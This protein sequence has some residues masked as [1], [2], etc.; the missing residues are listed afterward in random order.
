[1]AEPS[2]T[3]GRAAELAAMVQGIRDR[4][5]ARYPGGSAAGIALPDLT[6]VLHARDAAEGKV[7]AIGTVNPRS[8]GLLNSAVQG[9][10]R[11]VARAL[12]WHVREQIEYNRAVVVALVAI[13][14]S[15]NEGNR[16]IAGLAHSQAAHAEAGRAL[17]LNLT[18]DLTRSL[19]E[20]LAALRS[21]YQAVHAAFAR[22]LDSLRETG[23]AIGAESRAV[24]AEFGDLRTNW[25][26]W[27][28]G[29]ERKLEATETHLLRSL[30]E[31]QI[32]YQQ[33]LA[34]VH[35]ALQKQI[36]A[37]VARTRAE[38][39]H[40]IHS[41][42]RLIRQ[43]LAPPS[44]EP[45]AV[46]APAGAVPEAFDSTAFAERFRGT[47]EYVRDTQRFYVPYFRMCR[48][49]LD[50]GCGRGE[51][52]ELMR[53]ALIPARGIDLGP[54]AIALCRSKGLEAE[55]AD[56]F[57]YLTGSEDGSL[58]GIFSAQVVEHLPP[59]RL[60]E[61][62]HLAAR[63]LVSG[64]VMVIETPNPECLAIFASHFYLDP[65]H[66]RPVP[67]QLL[68]FHLEEAGMGRFE[69]HRRSAAA[70]TMPSLN[71]LPAEFRDAFFGGLDYAVVAKKL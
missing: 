32:A 68:A 47:E 59:G 20:G 12:D 22:D 28:D 26:Q 39:E 62:I 33:R 34:G 8:P 1:M 52:L 69:F 67:P 42:L 65:T 41:E 21:E 46:A 53:D 51:F 27:R 29:W 55:L 14:E 2:E 44:Y 58:D 24:A 31:L 66:Q 35:G 48:R 16:A 23:R 50:I 7:A 43:R 9:V 13:H 70:E 37:D 63:K 56:M 61:M 30:V 5:R 60:P 40:V 4:V 10:K 11:V 15:L 45:A 25:T 19:T 36:W 57:A 18:A 49:V 64:G 17:A 38:I 6:A 71:A 3:N 54:E